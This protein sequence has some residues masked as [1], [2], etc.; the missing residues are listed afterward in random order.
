MASNFCISPLTIL[1]NNL[2]NELNQMNLQSLKHV[3][4]DLIPGG[5]QDRISTGWDVFSILLQRNVIG[6]EPEKMAFLLGIIKELRPERIDLVSMVKRYIEKYYEQPKAILDEDDFSSDSYRISRCSTPTLV[7]HADCCAQGCAVRC[8]ACFD[9]NCNPCQYC[10]GCCCCVIVVILFSFLAVMAAVFWYT[11]SFPGVNDYLHSKE[12]LRDAGPAIIG[13]LAF[14]AACCVLC[15]IYISVKKRRNNLPYSVLYSV[16]NA[17]STQ[18][19]RG[20]Y[21]DSE[22]T[23]TSCSGYERRI[24]RSRRREHSCSS[25][26]ITASS[27]FASTSFRGS[28]PDPNGLSREINAEQKNNDNDPLV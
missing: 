23:R 28:P 5:Q 17:R 10:S 7:D 15:G 11:R 16:S 18:A 8:G 4:R 20:S 26:P 21:A 9:C 14:I 24:D 12:N 1:L 13:I 2:S 3:C 27:S 19:V 6:E 25:G 22:S